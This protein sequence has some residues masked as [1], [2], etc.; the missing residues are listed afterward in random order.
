MTALVLGAGAIGAFA[1]DHNWGAS[2]T[3]HGK[4]SRC[5]QIEF[6][7]DDRPAVREE[8]TFNIARSQAPTLRA[9]LGQGLGI[10]VFAGSSSDYVVHVCKAAAS[11]SSSSSANL[12][13]ISAGFSN[14]ELSAHGPDDGRWTAYLIVEAPAGVGFDLSTENG[15]LELRDLSG[16]IT[17]RAM[18]GPVSLERCTGEV[19]ART[20]NGPLSFSGDSGKLRLRTQNGPLSI[21][22]AGD[23]WNQGNLE[24]STE[25][26]PVSLSVAQGYSSGVR[27]ESRG[28]SPVSCR[29]CS[30]TQRT[31]DDNG[32]TI[33]IGGDPVVVRL[34]TVNGPVSVGPHGTRDDD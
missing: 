17:A 7:F 19:D 28:Y 30:K 29:E 33:Q 27:V 21:S 32:R 25:N 11:Y 12:A 24:G 3:S 14:G 10:T 23:R 20:E 8:Q 15:P 26:G 6:S 1:N 4:I 31:W 9:H 2:M 22:L 5:D 18:N 16:K 34:S 13:A